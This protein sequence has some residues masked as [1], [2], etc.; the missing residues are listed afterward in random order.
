M[1]MRFVTQGELQLPARTGSEA[2]STALAHEGET[3]DPIGAENTIY[4]ENIGAALAHG[5]H[6]VGDGGNQSAD[7]HASVPLVTSAEIMPLG[8]TDPN[9]LR[10]A[11]AASPVRKRARKETSVLQVNSPTRRST[12]ERHTPLLR[13]RCLS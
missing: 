4:A 7:A 5:G 11:S 2:P 3:I 1:M 6:E 8:T 13:L 9:A 10:E 12:R